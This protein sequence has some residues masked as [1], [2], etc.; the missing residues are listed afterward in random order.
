MPP[1]SPESR[2]AAIAVVLA[3]VV[4]ACGRS[5]PPRLRAVALPGASAMAA[6]AAT[7][8][9]R[10]QLQNVGGRTL[11]LDGVVPACGCRSL[12]PLPERL[13]AG[14]STVLTIACR[15][16][17]TVTDAVRELH[18][19]SS[20]PSAIDTALPVTLPGGR[21]GPEPSALYFGYVAVGES[22]TL[23]V[24]LPAAVALASLAP[25]SDPSLMLEALPARRDGRPGVRV[26]F[27]PRTAGVLRADLDL[28]PDAARVA[29][30]G[31]GHRGVL[32]FPAEL[33]AATASS[34]SII[35]VMGID[36]EPLVLTH[37]DY[38]PGITGELR[39]VL[40]GRQY[41]LTLY[42]RRGLVPPSDAAIRLRTGAGSEPVVSIPV[43]RQ[44][45]PAS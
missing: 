4:A 41:R 23:D 28:G 35:T 29:V 34:P 20:D 31:I 40:P 39:A 44:G 7:V 3:A 17:R 14:A 33:A 16:P 38:P 9:A 45:P 11:R 1:C 37:V 13:A 25:P 15:S 27:T 2:R 24:V 6:A 36:D 42:V 12:S 22:A 5:D 8:E 30:A 10:Y 19:R 32:A 18:V 21:A 43:A 26:R